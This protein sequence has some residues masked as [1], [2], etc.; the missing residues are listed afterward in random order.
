MGVYRPPVAE[1]VPSTFVSTFVSYVRGIKS[2][3]PN[4][5]CDSGFCG[6]G[7]SFNSNTTF[8]RLPFE[9]RAVPSP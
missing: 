5:L 9:A 6:E 8:P 4:Q 3:Q 7:P 1:A 2:K